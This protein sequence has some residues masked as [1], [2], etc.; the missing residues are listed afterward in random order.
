[1]LFKIRRALA[2]CSALFVP[3]SFSAAHAQD[4]QISVYG[5]YQTAPHSDVDVSDGTNFTAGWEGNSFK[6]PQ[7]YGVRGTWWL[8]DLGKPNLGLSI[9]YTH[10]KVYADDETF[11]KTPGWTHFEFTDG[12]NLLMVNAL[13]R[14][15]EPGRKWTPYI[16]AGAGINVPHVE[17]TRP[18]GKTFDYEFGGMTLQAQA[19]ISYQ[20][21]ERW[22]MFGEYKGNYSF[23]DVPIDNGARLKTNI[24]TNAIN[25]GVSFHF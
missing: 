23:V 24:L 15:Q 9:D 5:G 2:L 19:G 7:Y 18:S 11:R 17:V 10:A 6:A 21:S 16:G 12:L 4:L 14:F 25:L 3:A 1:M 13:Y 22:S 20:I 8:T